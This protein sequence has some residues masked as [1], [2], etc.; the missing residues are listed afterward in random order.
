[1]DRRTSTVGRK[2]AQIVP[3][4]GENLKIAIL[5][6]FPLETISISKPKDTLNLKFIR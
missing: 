6:D 3:K 1:M 5:E 4:Q 2:I